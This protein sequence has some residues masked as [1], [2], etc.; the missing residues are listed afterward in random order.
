M[1]VKPAP[2]GRR[3]SEY[4]RFRRCPFGYAG[5]LGVPRAGCRVRRPGRFA[6]GP[7]HRHVVSAAGELKSGQ[8]KPLVQV[9]PLE[10]DMRRLLSTCALRARVVGAVRVGPPR[11]PAAKGMQ[12]GSGRSLQGKLIPGRGKVECQGIKAWQGQ[13]AAG[14]GVGAWERPGLRCCCGCR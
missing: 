13:L 9:A 1:R 4:K 10:N 6:T 11:P 7:A 8:V 3:P 5:S 12:A 14:T 2:Q